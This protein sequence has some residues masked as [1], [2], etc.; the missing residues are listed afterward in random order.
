MKS[1]FGY[2]RYQPYGLSQSIW[3][4]TLSLWSVA[5]HTLYGTAPYRYAH[6]QNGLACKV[7]G[8]HKAASTIAHSHCLAFA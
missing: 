6:T 3:K 1:M 5:N 8:L 7:Q 2:T 4:P